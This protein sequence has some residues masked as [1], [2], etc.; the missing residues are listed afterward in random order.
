MSFTGSGVTIIRNPVCNPHD[1]EYFNGKIYWGD[2]DGLERAN[3]DGSGIDTIISGANVN[4]LTIDGTNDRIY[5]VDYIENRIKC[6]DLDGSNRMDIMGGLGNLT[7]VDTD[8]NPS[9]V[10][11]EFESELSIAFE[12]LQNYPNPFNPSTTI[13]YQ[14]PSRAHVVLKVFDML[15]RE[16]TTLVNGVEERGHKS[17]QWNSGSVSSGVYFCRIQAGGY[18]DAKK[19]VVLR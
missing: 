5:W 8:F 10:P 11:V 16:V 15:G 12:L 3:T 14:L 7:G 6:V 4:G 13:R 19:L 17:A 2:G 18:V 9:A 1:I